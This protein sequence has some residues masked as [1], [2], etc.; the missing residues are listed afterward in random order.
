[1]LLHYH[2]GRALQE[3]GQLGPAEASFREAVRLAPAEAE[4]H[5]RLAA[6][7]AGQ[8]KREEAADSYRNALRLRPD[9]S[10][11]HMGL[12]NVLRDLARLDEALV[13]FGHALRLRPTDM[14]RTNLATILPPVYTSAQ[15]V[16]RWRD[17]LAGEVRRLHDEGR[18]VDLTRQTAAPNFYL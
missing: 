14:L 2:L 3:R 13:E 17:R 10:E 1:G 7:L 8:G 16:S 9:H 6:V 5:Y 18:G 11:A 4:G 12:G 15:D